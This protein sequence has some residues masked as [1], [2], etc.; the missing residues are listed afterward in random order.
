MVWAAAVDPR[1]KGLE[2]E[3]TTQEA[4]DCAQEAARGARSVAGMADLARRA[5]LKPGGSFQ[6]ASPAIICLCLCRGAE[7]CCFGFP[8]CQLA[9]LGGQRI[10]GSAMLHL[11]GPE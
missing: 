5:L 10:G 9:D 2:L 6:V 8:S 3:N 11:H 7:V 4:L 1:H